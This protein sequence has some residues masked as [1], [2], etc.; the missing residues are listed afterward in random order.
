MSERY[1]PRSVDAEQAVLGGLM[2]DNERWDEVVLMLRGEDFSL[3]AHRV[4]FRTMSEL[5]TSG[6]PFDLITLS[7]HIEKTNNIEAL[8]GFAY[9]AELS[10]NTPSAAN[11][12]A[13]AR[14]VAEKSM[15]RQL[16]E[17]GNALITDVAAPDATPRTVLESAERRLFSLSQTGMLHERCEVSL[18]SAMELALRQ[19]EEGLNAGGMTGTPTGFDELDEMTCGLQPGD[20][21]L[22]AARPSMGK[23]ALG[24][25]FCL[26][27]LCNRT[28]ETVFLFSIEMS[29]E[30]L[31]LRFLSML[32]RVELTRLR[33]SMMDDEEWARVTATM[34]RFMNEASFIGD[35]NR[36]II[37][38]TSFQTPS[39]LRASARRYVRLYGRPSLIMVD[40]LQLIRSPDQEN[41]TQEIAEIS[42]ALKALGKELGCPVLALSQLNRQV[43]QRADKRP[44]NGDLRD[45]GALEQDADLIMFIYRDE[46]YN[47]GTLDKGVA[48]IIVS[49]QRQG[50]TGTI[51]VNFDGRYTLFS[52]FERGW[53]FDRAGGN[54]YVN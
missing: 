21:I 36:L 19:L 9:L 7:E 46:V 51:R 32:S 4:I 34:G 37:D 43:E 30:Q 20:L 3:A 40:Y 6:Q 41:R 31:I 11:I 33:S 8:G 28:D 13:Y 47:S 26:N 52:P 23:T 27:A 10:K 53:N 5:A 24:L 12:I 50:P 14:I 29:R 38:D 39:S 44:N 45:S 1:I 22:L 54:A 35:G 42:R 49:K 15:L 48:E 25:T 17:T 16:Q 18:T 2:L